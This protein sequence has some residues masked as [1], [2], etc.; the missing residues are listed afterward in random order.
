MRF[1]TPIIILQQSVHAFH[2]RL[3]HDPR[4]VAGHQYNELDV[5]VATALPGA[6]DDR[7]IGSGNSICSALRTSGWSSRS[8]GHLRKVTCAGTPFPTG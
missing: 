8:M 7:V 6:S 3:N 5:V 2:N 4:D 1:A